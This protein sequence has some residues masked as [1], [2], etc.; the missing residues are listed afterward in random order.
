MFTK[1]NDWSI[2]IGMELSKKMKEFTRHKRLSMKAKDVLD[3]LMNGSVKKD[4]RLGR[5]IAIKNLGILFEP[6][7]KINFEYFLK[8]YSS[9]ITLI[10]VWP[11]VIKSNN[12]F[13]LTEEEGIKI[14]LTNLTYTRYEV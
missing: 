13:F 2:D 3:E 10:I 12:I 7:L 14:D 6:E 5:Y 1:S 4:E 9:E 11:G 8:T